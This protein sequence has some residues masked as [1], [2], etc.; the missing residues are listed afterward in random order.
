SASNFDSWMAVVTILC[1]GSVAV[2]TRGLMQRLLILIGLIAA[3]LI[4][5][6]V[7]NGFGLGKPVDYSALSQAAWFGLPQFTAPAFN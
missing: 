4:Y 3:Y 5:V 1:I 2:F 6:V 7:T